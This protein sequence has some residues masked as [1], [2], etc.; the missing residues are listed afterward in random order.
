MKIILKEY[1][2]NVGGMGDIVEV[3]HGYGRNYLIPRG[4]AVRANTDNVARLEHERG[5]IERQKAR[6]LELAE[7]LA[8]RLS[9]FSCTI[10]KAVG[11]GGKLYGSVTSIDLE[12]HLHEAGFTDVH[13]RQI[14]LGQPIKELGEFDVKIKVHPDVQSQI[15][16]QVVARPE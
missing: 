5:Q 13:R 12:D 9:S 4:L 14:E 16:V 15:K 3:A 2:P 7:S 8:S 1:V 11:E 10:E 6:H